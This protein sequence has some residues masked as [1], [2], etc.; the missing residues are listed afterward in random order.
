MQISVHRYSYT[1]R[2][3]FELAIVCFGKTQLLKMLGFDF[4]LLYGL[5]KRFGSLSRKPVNSRFQLF[6]QVSQTP[7]N[8]SRLPDRRLGK[9]PRNLSP[10][11][12]SA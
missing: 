8:S 6:S 4:D 7:K 11:L 2:C 1:A 9:L 5:P 12:C 10:C 3:R